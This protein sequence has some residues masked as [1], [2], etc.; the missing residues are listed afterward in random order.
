MLTITQR[1]L[2]METL[3]EQQG[4]KILLKV[5]LSVT[6]AWTPPVMLLYL[7]VAIYSAGPA[8]TSGLK[9]GLTGKFALSARLVSARTKLFPSMVVEIQ[10][11]KIQEKKCHLAHKAREVNQLPI[12]HSLGLDLEGVRV[13]VSI[14]LLGLVLSPLD[15]LPPTSTLV[16]RD[17]DPLSLDHIKQLK[18]HFCTKYFFGLLGPSSFG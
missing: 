13:G 17:Q 5:P 15:S 3:Q 2:M 8:S 4:V 18:K 10:M 9:P 1:D 16:R 11:Q 6:Y 14:C 7:C 12:T